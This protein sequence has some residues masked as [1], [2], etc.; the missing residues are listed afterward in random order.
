MEK[1][2][3]VGKIPLA[4]QTSFTFTIVKGC[5]RLDNGGNLFCQYFVIFYVS[6]GWI[7][8]VQNSNIAIHF[9]R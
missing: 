2:A 7:Y 3:K 5:L 4:T 8:Y 6:C 1:L 9:H